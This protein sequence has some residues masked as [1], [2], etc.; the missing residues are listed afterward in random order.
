[1]NEYFLVVLTKMV[2]RIMV[3]LLTVERGTEETARRNIVE[4]EINT[5]I[6][7]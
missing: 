4:G 7:H 2:D 1:M 3:K 6:N 5:V